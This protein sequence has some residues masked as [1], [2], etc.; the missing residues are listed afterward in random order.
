MDAHSPHQISER[1]RVETPDEVSAEHGVR[2]GQ[3]Q[4]THGFLSSDAGT[5]R[6][7]SV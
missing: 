6:A 2:T 3:H 7:L 5:A 4:D 1:R